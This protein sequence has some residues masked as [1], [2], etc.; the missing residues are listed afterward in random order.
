MH[1]LEHEIESKDCSLISHGKRWHQAHDVPFIT[2]LS[3]KLQESQW[4]RQL[5][6]MYVVQQKLESLQDVGHALH[7]PQIWFDVLAFF[8]ESLLTQTLLRIRIRKITIVWEIHR[9]GFHI[10]H[11]VM[12][13]FGTDSYECLGLKKG[14]CALD[15]SFESHR[16]DDIALE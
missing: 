13:V 4:Q 11:D 14:R 6:S 12:L 15:L 5:F 3:T 10:F 1:I 8:L 9:S 2:S 16:S 7:K